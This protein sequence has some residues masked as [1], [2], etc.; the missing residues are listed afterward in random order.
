MCSSPSF[1]PNLFSTGFDKVKWE[2]LLRNQHSPFINK[3][4]GKAYPPGST[5]KII[6]AL[7]ILE[8]G[9]N[10]NEKIFCNGSIQV[11]DRTFKCWKKSGHGYVNIYNAISSSCNCYFYKMGINTGIENMYKIAKILGL[12]EKLGIELAGESRGINPN[13]RWKENVFSEKWTLGDTA[14]ASIGQGFV[15]TTPLQL[16]MMISRIA[17]GKIIMPSL[18]K[19]HRKNFSALAL[20]FKKEKFRNIKNRAC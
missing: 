17:S 7:A 15:L 4:I 6:T 3:V 2:N 14:N 5:W 11:G 8:S 1:D 13:K 20:P 19:G 12:G 10:P 16:L 9:V 18:L